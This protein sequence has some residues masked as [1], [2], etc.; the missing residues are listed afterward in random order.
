MATSDS[1]RALWRVVVGN[2]VVVQYAQFE[3]V[4]RANRTMGYL[5]VGMCAAFTM[6]GLHHAVRR[7]PASAGKATEA[8]SPD[9]PSSM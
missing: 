2:R 1:G 8:P 9:A 4:R 5:V 7:R 6:I 3:A